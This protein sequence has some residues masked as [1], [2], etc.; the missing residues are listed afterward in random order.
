[1]SRV[2]HV[3]QPY[4]RGHLIVV[5]DCGDLDR[6][7]RF[8]TGLLGYVRES[9]PGGCYQT[10]LPA[11]GRGIEILLQRVPEAKVESAKNRLHLDLRTADLDAEVERAVALGARRPAGPP[12]AESGMRWHVLADP[13]GNEFC[14]LQPPPAYWQIYPPGE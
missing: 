1:M 8:W 12:I 14:V 7:A 10:L 5:I 11:D 13:D 4:P 6:A 3:P 9:P 2:S